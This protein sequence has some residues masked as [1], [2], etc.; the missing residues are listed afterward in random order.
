MWRRRS[1][2]SEDSVVCIACGG[3]LPREEAREYDKEGNRWERRDKEFEYLCKACHGELS[4]QPR[5]GL[6]QTLETVVI[7]GQ[8]HEEFVERYL[9]AVEDCEA[10]EEP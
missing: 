3:S 7:P 8:D 6:E 5:N 10:E 2:G 9:C 1:D 4:H